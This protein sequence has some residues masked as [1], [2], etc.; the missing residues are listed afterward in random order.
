MNTSDRGI[1]KNP[2]RLNVASLSVNLLMRSQAATI[3]A[4][5]PGR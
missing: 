5:Q 2:N 1:A 3:M 4:M